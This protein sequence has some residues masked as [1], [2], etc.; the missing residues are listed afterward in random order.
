MPEP[1]D[2][3]RSRAILIGTA[4][5]QDPKFLPLPAAGNSLREMREVLTDPRLCGWPPDRVTVLENPADMPVLVQYLRRVA[6]STDDVLLVYFVGHGV[7]LPRGQLCLVVTGTNAEHADITG[8]EY[9]RVRDALT[10]SP[11]RVKVAIL[12]CCYSGRAIEAASA[13]TEI[14]DSTDVRGVYTLTASDHTAHVVPLDQQADTTT[15]FTGELLGLIRT[16]IPG[17]PQQ[18]TLGGLYPHLRRRLDQRGLPAPNQRGT[19]TADRF[20]ITRNAAHRSG[21]PPPHLADHEHPPEPASEVEPVPAGRD[22]RRRIVL[23]AGLAAAAGVPTAV[24]LSRSSSAG[25]RLRALT[26]LKGHTRDI[27]SLA[28][29]PDGKI[30]ASGS[31]DQTARLWDVRARR[32]M[33]A[34]LADRTGNGGALVSV[35]FSPDGK[36]LA[37]CL[38]GTGAGG[39]GVN[40]IKL[41][42]VA[43]GHSTA[44]FT[45]GTDNVTDVDNE[46]ALYSVAFGPGGK[47]L[48]S[49]GLGKDPIRLWDVATGHYTP[50]KSPSAYGSVALA[51]GGACYAVAFS[52]DGTTLATGSED[53]LIRLWDPAKPTKTPSYRSTPN[54]LSPV[55][56]LAFSHDGRTLAS[57]H[58]DGVIRIWDLTKPHDPVPLDNPSHADSGGN[59][60]AL[61]PDGKTLIGTGGQS[62]RTIRVWNVTTGHLTGIDQAWSVTAVA[63]SPDGTTLATGGGDTST[64]MKLWNLETS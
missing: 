40:R 18:L 45:A 9:Q 31:A 62:Q 48:A 19:D 34:P 42:D 25:P 39:L 44:T 36:T 49:G 11:A 8:L 46:V 59:T 14:A 63:F 50:L 64:T 1:P 32:P 35:A 5:Y 41:W 29:S 15:S 3:T 61:S 38:A 47:T 58:R 52:P 51:S 56:S 43:T 26:T 60:V 33:G 23:L 27:E 37:A 55:H 30:L 24:F 17:G 54:L 7:I 2:Y 22:I 20:A 13:A 6:R 10:D 12:D 4:S 28:F 57:G 16:G 53:G 21:P